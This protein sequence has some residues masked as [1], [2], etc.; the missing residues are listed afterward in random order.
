MSL[1]DDVARQLTHA[2]YDIVR[3]ENAEPLER[4]RA[5][6]GAVLDLLNSHGLI[7]HPLRRQLV[8]RDLPPS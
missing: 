3:A 8:E 1:G 7:D 6:E 2:I 5:L 4:I